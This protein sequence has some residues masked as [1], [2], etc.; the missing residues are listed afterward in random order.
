MQEPHSTPRYEDPGS[1]LGM[2]TEEYGLGFG[3]SAVGIQGLNR[4][5]TFF[6]CFLF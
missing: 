4:A 6:V 5:N 2:A 1:M 3:T